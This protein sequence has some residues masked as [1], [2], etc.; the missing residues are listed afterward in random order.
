M[1]DYVDS[2][3]AAVRDFLG[4]RTMTNATLREHRSCDDVPVF[5]AEA[6]PRPVQWSSQVANHL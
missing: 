3:I 4:E 2:A 6:G 1:P 5:S